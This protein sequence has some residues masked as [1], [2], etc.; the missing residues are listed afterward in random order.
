MSMFEENEDEL[1]VSNLRFTQEEIGGFFRQSKCVYTWRFTL[2]NV[3]R[4]VVLEHS[5]L[6]GKRVI[7]F[8][9]KELVRT[10][11]YTYSFRYFFAIDKHN[12]LIHQSNTSYEMK[13]DDKSFQ[14]LINQ[15]KLERYNAIRE[16]Y[17]RENPM[18]LQ[19]IEPEPKKENPDDD[20]QFVDENNNPV[21]LPENP[22]LRAQIIE[23]YRNYLAMQEKLDQDENEMK[24]KE[25]QEEEQKEEQKEELKVEENNKDILVNPIVENSQNIDLLNIEEPSIDEHVNN[26]LLDIPIQVPQSI[27]DVNKNL[28]IE[29]FSSFNFT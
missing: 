4:T 12:I 14:S 19:D 26:N 20:I 10:N 3:R 9:Q 2:D 13:I 29:E 17:I 21:Q 25:E 27:D 28:N 6:T 8:D 1:K 15:E 18:V 16:D 7:I 23:N 22:A 5:K 11:K 24:E